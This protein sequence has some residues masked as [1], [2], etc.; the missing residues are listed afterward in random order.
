MRMDHAAGAQRRA[1]L[2]A[3][4]G[5]APAR[6][7]RC[8]E[9]R[10]GALRAA[11]SRAA[12]VRERARRRS[13]D[14]R[15][16][17][18]RDRGDPRRPPASPAATRPSASSRRCGSRSTTSSADRRGTAARLGPAP[19]ERPLCRDFLPL[20]GRSPREAVPGR[21]RPRLRLPARAPG[22]RLRAHPAG[23]AALARRDRA[24]RPGDRRQ[25]AGPLGPPTRRAQGRSGRSTGMTPPPAATA[26]PPI[27]RARGS[28]PAPHRASRAASQ[29]PRAEP[30]RSRRRSGPRCRGRRCAD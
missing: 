2:V 13:D 25:P 14:H 5:R 30:S 28:G 16:R 12:I 15:P 18:R 9:L 3:E 10:R 21:P 27:A 26:A 4:L 17:R 22:L 8:R 24:G 7:A 29:D 20:P 1:D 6:A 11:G 19:R 23:A